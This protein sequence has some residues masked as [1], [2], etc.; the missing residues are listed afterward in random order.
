MSINLDELD[1]M[2][3]EQLRDMDAKRRPANADDMRAAALDKLRNHRPAER[4]TEFVRNTAQATPKMI[5]FVMVLLRKLDA[6]NAPV[7]AVAREWWMK[8]AIVDEDT[9]RVTGSTLNRDQ[10]SDVITRLKGHLDG[11][12]VVVDAPVAPVAPDTTPNPRHALQDVLKALPMQHHSG[13]RY[14]IPHTDNPDAYTYVWMKE[15]K[16]TGNRY[17]VTGVGGGLG[18]LVWSFCKIE[19]GAL[20]IARRI[21]EDPHA[22]MIRYGQVVGACGHCGRTLTNQASR[23]AGIGPVCAAKS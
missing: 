12:Q 10:V 1:S 4:T 17:L 18:D 9:N 23:D 2:T 7:A 6:H 8:T 3:P 11:P 5:G 21:A 15:S 16:R 22:A 20:T 13:T 19:N 14:A